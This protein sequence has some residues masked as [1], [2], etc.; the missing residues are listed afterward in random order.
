VDHDLRLNVDQLCWLLC[1]RQGSVAA[2]VVTLGVTDNGTL[3]QSWR[4]PR[5]RGRAAHCYTWT[6][7]GA[8]P[9]AATGPGH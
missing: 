6:R 7:R 5:R 9:Q 4:L 3:A 2:V 1:V 8:G